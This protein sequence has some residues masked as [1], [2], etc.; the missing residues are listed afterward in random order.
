[1]IRRTVDDIVKYI[2]IFNFK[3]WKYDLFIIF[4]YNKLYVNIITPV[5]L[6]VKQYKLFILFYI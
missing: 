4:T 1:M 5:S 2:Y 6:R 3:L